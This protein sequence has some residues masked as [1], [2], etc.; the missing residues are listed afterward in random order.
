MVLVRPSSARGRG[1]WLLIWRLQRPHGAPAGESIYLPTVVPSCIFVYSVRNQTHHARGRDGD[2]GTGRGGGRRGE[3]EGGW[4]DIA[5]AAIWRRI[6][7]VVFVVH[8]ISSISFF[9]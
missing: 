4:G 3:W 7:D 9:V 8:H 5:V 2:G 1:T 6:L